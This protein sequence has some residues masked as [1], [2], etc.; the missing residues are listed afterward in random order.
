MSKLELPNIDNS[1]FKEILQQQIALKSSYLGNNFQLHGPN[2]GHRIKIYIKDNKISPSS[3]SFLSNASSKNFRVSEV[4]KLI[5]DCLKDY[6]I[7]DMCISFNTTDLPIKGVLNM[8]RPLNQHGYFLYPLTFSSYN[9]RQNNVDNLNADEITAY[10]KEKEIPKEE[11]IHKLYSN[12]IPGDDKSRYFLYAG[13]NTDIFDSKMYVGPPYLWHYCPPADRPY[14]KNIASDCFTPW[15]D[16]LKYKYILCA[17]GQKHVIADR[18]K[19]LLKINSV[20]FKGID[21]YEE[22]FYYKLKNKEN[23]ISID[24]PQHIRPILEMLEK[25]DELYDKIVANNKKFIDEELNYSQIKL[26][27]AILLNGLA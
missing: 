15:I 17:R 7:K 1:A 27:M 13:K 4:Y 2:P 26:Y 9:L 22:F 5:D 3:P 6:K 11:K 19:S 23:Y 25:D 24:N 12:G 18:Y 14:V 16:H 21:R 20:I 10:L 8:C